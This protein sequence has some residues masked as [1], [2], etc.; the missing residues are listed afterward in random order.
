V[1]EHRGSPV[2]NFLIKFAMIG[3]ATVSGEVRGILLNMTSQKTNFNSTSR[4]NAR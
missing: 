1:V 3:F 4:T 2:A